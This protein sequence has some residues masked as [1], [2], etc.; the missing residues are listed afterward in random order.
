M[1]SQSHINTCTKASFKD[2]ENEK[3]LNKE[4][5]KLRIAATGY[6]HT[7]SYMTK[8][9][10]ILKSKFHR[11]FGY[12]YSEKERMLTNQNVKSSKMKS[13]YIN[14]RPHNQTL[15]YILSIM[16]FSCQ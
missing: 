2:K 14:D 4:H 15:G 5:A 3:R 7:S 10:I 16:A 1:T 13:E 11:Y 12:T 6:I 8:L 9:T